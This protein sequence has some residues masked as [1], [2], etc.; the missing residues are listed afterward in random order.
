MCDCYSAECSGGCG[1]LISIHIA[2][3]CTDRKNVEAYCHKCTP[4][5]EKNLLGSIPEDAN[6]LHGIVECADGIEGG[7]D[8]VTGALPGDVVLFVIHDKAA[9]GIHLN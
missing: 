5:V 2:D 4:E 1:R 6:V 7:Y 8:Q 9:Y 3:F